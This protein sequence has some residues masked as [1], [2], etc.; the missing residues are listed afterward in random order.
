MYKQSILLLFSGL[1]FGE[2]LIIPRYA[3]IVSERTVSSST[4]DFIIAGG[5][6]TGLTLAD[7]LTEDPAGTWHLLLHFGEEILISSS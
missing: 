6:I 1:L 7:R 4:Y 3:T 2:A 5:G